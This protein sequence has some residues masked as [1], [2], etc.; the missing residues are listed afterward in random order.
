M[1]VFLAYQ[2]SRPL[3]VIKE[4]LNNVKKYYEEFIPGIDFIHCEQY[5]FQ[6]IGVYYL[7]TD[8]KSIKFNFFSKS[9][10][11]LNVSIQIPAGYKKISTDISQLS[12]ILESNPEKI[13]NIVPPYVHISVNLRNKAINIHSDYLGMGKLYSL[14][15]KTG[16]VYSNKL[17]ALFLF[18]K[19]KIYSDERAISA[20]SSAGWFVGED[21]PYL[22]AK[23]VLGGQ[24]IV[25]VARKDI[26]I[27]TFNVFKPLLSKKMASLEENLKGIIFDTQ[28]FFEFFPEKKVRGMLS[29]GKD[30]R[31]V[32]SVL[33]KSKI[34]CYFTTLG[35][36]QGEID[37]AKELLRL[38]AFSGEHK[39]VLN[40]TERRLFTLNLVD[41][42]SLLH[43]VYDGDYT[44][45]KQKQ[46]IV[47]KSFYS[48]PTPVFGGA[49]GEI[50]GP[51]YF[52]QKLVEK[53]NNN[54]INPYERLFKSLTGTMLNSAQSLN[55]FSNSL[56]SFK[57]Y[58]RSNLDFLR[59]EE[60]LVFY[61]LF[62]RVRRW[63]P[64][65]GSIGGYSPFV[66]SQFVRLVFSQD[67]NQRIDTY[68]HKLV[69]NS[70]V[71]QWKEVAY[72]K[73]NRKKHPV[74]YKSKYNYRTWQNEDREDAER[75]LFEGK[76]WREFFKYTNVLDKWQDATGG[77]DIENRYE[78]MVLRITWLQSLYH[79]IN[80]LNIYIDSLD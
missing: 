21:T 3:G 39:I 53:L 5:K 62:E 63:I 68:L 61:Y 41:R 58:V 19:N 16:V 20:F 49:A 14:R 32:A 40:R 38:A 9:S 4:S 78:G 12:K 30:S 59:S 8:Y 42:L 23:R 31:L 51:I 60:V 24:H 2:D 56:L 27:R 47:P 46:N 10:D 48:L 73:D 77:G 6:D 34:P 67:I 57:E 66:T 54:L 26:N 11:Y 74:D 18:T 13:I 52:N 70:F 17:A 33:L 44:L 37:T 64:L 25:L 45:I 71:P 43:T 75:L 65:S 35:P 69:T 72:F 80:K 22:G 15:T 7:Q 36:I 28:E 29:G 1:Q 76:D 55:D 79:H 50:A